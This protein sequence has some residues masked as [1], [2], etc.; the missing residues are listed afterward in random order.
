MFFT[1]ISVIFFCSAVYLTIKL[2]FP[3]RKVF[4]VVLNKGNHTSLQAL[5]VSLAS[6]IGTGNLVGITT[7]LI[8]GGPGVL[9]WMWIYAFF[10]SS[11][12]LLENSFAV[13]YREEINNE[14]IGGASHYITK[15]LGKKKLGFLFAACLFI[16]NGIL[17]P[18][19]QINT[20]VMTVNYIFDIKPL[21][22]VIVL[23]VILI[24]FVFR[25]T[26]K[27]V[28]ITDF[29]VPI[30]ASTFVLVITFLIC[31]NI[32]TVPAVIILIIKSAFNFKAFGI[33]SCI[34]AFSLGVR[35]SIFSNEAGL[36]TTPT[37][38][39]M[40][41]CAN[42][43]TQ[44]YFQML[45]VFIDTLLL[46]TL[47]GI[48]ILQSNFDFSSSAG[49]D[50]IIDILTLKLGNFGKTLALFFLLA[51]AF[52]SILGE[53][54]MGESNMLSI[55]KDRQNIFKIFYRII[56]GLITFFGAYYSTESAMKVIDY[57]LVLLGSINLVAIFL[58]NRKLKILQK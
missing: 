14:Y 45:G 37:F 4:G 33:S 44:G 16:T 5:L 41:N 7:G 40:A 46:C 2:K 27:I 48:F 31:L 23:L 17:F 15:G 47:M 52:S 13:I 18:P 25:G 39:A 19:L 3:Q 35:R 26:K 24:I 43:T 42:P 53:F 11:F 57:G 54:Y 36:G 28:K 29:I 12:S 56:F 10:S 1:V 20:I 38:S 22:I 9:F 8:L 21:Y 32:E 49:A 51:F 34:F 55:V 50:V 30:M 58:L 6:H